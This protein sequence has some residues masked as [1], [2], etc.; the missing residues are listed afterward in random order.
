MPLM[1]KH[2]PWLVSGIFLSTGSFPHPMVLA[3]SSDSLR[4]SLD[5]LDQPLAPPPERLF[6]APPEIHTTPE[7]SPFQA[8]SLGK[9]LSESIQFVPDPPPGSDR[10]SP[11][12]Q[13]DLGRRGPGDDDGYLTALV[14]S[15]G[16][17]LTTMTHPSF[18]VFIP[19][20]PQTVESITFSLYHSLSGN[21]QEFPVLT[22]D[23]LPG[24]VEIT[25]PSNVQPLEIGESYDWLVTVT[26]NLPS[27][28]DGTNGSSGIDYSYERYVVASIQR[29]QPSSELE[30][31][32]AIA[33]SSRDKAATYARHGI[34]Q[35]ALTQLGTIYRTDA[36]NEDLA[37]DWTS[38]LTAV[39]L[40]SH[41]YFPFTIPF[42]SASL[43]QKAIVPCCSLEEASS[44]A[45]EF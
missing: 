10:G 37:R 16:I 14:P 9:S 38:L 23:Y 8:K 42:D 17:A 36:A 32:L 2:L 33:T 34:W 45:Q 28:T 35:D 44:V 19:G 31:E 26:Y 41:P 29:Q 18:W 11:G 15:E 25:L 24:V 30:Q 6:E 5:Q 1:L 22:H 13:V 20:E 7:K 4:H 12:Q 3:H 43:S 27:E 21:L 40:E 39:D